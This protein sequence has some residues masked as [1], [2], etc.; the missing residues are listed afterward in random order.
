MEMDLKLNFSV[1]D[2]KPRSSRGKKS[3]TEEVGSRLELEPTRLTLNLLSVDPV[4]K[5][6]TGT[7]WSWIPGRSKLV[8]N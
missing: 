3:Y 2:Q 6:G 5:R 1:T 4:E 7:P 8:R